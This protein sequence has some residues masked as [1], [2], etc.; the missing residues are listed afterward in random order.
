MTPIGVD[1]VISSD[2]S[3]QVRRV[4]VGQKWQVVEQGRQWEDAAGRHVLIMW[5]GGEVR[6]ILLRAETLTWEVIPPSGGKVAV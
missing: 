5:A 1:C 2:G 6:E 4:Q 3:V